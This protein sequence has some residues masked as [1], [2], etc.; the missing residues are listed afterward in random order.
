MLSGN[1]A[2][3]IRTRLLSSVAFPA[4]VRGLSRVL[5]REFV[6]DISVA[7]ISR[8]GLAAMR[9]VVERLQLD[10]EH[11][12][13]G[14]THRP[15]PLEGDSTADWQARG[16]NLH[17]TGSWVYSSGLCGPNAAESVFWPGTV[18]WLDEE[19]PPQRRQLLADLGRPD[20]SA[21]VRGLLAT[22]L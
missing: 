2:G 14:H 16:A 6:T 8:A 13:F 17:A 5:R 7:G 1:G 10:C 9:E 21:A 22:P 19:G 12:V 3:P 11:V 4:T 15:G 18:T 20:F